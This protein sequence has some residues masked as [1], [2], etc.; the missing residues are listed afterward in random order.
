MLSWWVCGHKFKS[1][2]NKLKTWLLLEKLLNSQLSMTNKTIH[3]KTQQVLWNAAIIFTKC[4]NHLPLRHLIFPT[5]KLLY[6]GHIKETFLTQS[7]LQNNR[8]FDKSQ[9]IFFSSQKL[10]NFIFNS[11][12]KYDTWELCMRVMNGMLRNY[13]YRI[14]LNLV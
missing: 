8:N 2:F 5:S 3:C 6:S 10:L 12:V 1:C 7:K 13:Y 11:H 9:M 14:I 4:S